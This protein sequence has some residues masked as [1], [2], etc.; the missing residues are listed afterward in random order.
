MR[1]RDLRA[2]QPNEAVAGL[3]RVIEEGELMV[4]RQRREPQRQFGEIGRK[5]ISVDAVKAALR[6][7]P[8]LEPIVEVESS[9]W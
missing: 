8:P 1:C 3:Q 7:E 4:A 2:R 6:N 9:A 5:R